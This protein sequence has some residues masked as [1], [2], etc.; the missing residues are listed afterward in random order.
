MATIATREIT[1]DSASRKEIPSSLETVAAAVAVTSRIA[2]WS[3]TIVASMPRE[4][5]TSGV[6]YSEEFGNDRS[7]DRESGKSRATEMQLNANENGI[8]LATLKCS[9]NSIKELYLELTL[10]KIIK[11]LKHIWKNIQNEL[12]TQQ[13][14]NYQIILWIE[15]NFVTA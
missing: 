12:F 2:A 4:H 3:R 13:L 14:F 8:L 10:E 11:V 7:I 6:M 1:A 9:I 5:P 15:C